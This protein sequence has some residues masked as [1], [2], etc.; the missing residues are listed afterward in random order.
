MVQTDL[1][2]DNLC[3]FNQA[4]APMYYILDPIQNH[5]QFTVGETGVFS[6]VGLHTPG[7][8][9]DI[10]SSL[11]DGGRDNLLTLCQTPVPSMM[12][13]KGYASD[14]SIRNI[15]PPL[16]TQGL[17]YLN[18]NLQKIPGAQF[19]NFEKFSTRLAISK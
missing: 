6:G 3:G 10:S 13:N 2:S 11:V 9:I 16:P 18:D 12:S 15:G 4:A 14:A 17:N 7:E 1:K 5:T 19:K 8:V